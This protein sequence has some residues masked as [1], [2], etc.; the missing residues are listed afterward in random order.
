MNDQ[1]RSILL[2]I[3][4]RIAKGTAYRG[5]YN[6]LHLST[7]QKIAAVLPNVVEGDI[8]DRNEAANTLLDL[9]AE[10]EE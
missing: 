5:L 6:L 10:R 1:E 3:A 9:L 8:T 4:E 2:A 7:R